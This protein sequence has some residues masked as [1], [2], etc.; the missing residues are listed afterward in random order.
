MGQGSVP[1]VDAN[2]DG[3]DNLGQNVPP[4][5]GTGSQTARP[6]ASGTAAGKHNDIEGSNRNRAVRTGHL[7]IG[8]LLVSTAK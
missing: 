5:D 7:Q 3:C 2:S 1:T 4:H 8:L 6:L